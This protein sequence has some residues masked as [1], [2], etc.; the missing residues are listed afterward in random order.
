MVTPD[1]DKYGNYKLCLHYVFCIKVSLYVCFYIYI[2]TSFFSYNNV[3]TLFCY[4]LLNS[5][6]KIRFF[7]ILRVVLRDEEIVDVSFKHRDAFFYMIGSNIKSY[8]WAIHTNILIRLMYSVIHANIIGI[9]ALKS[10]TQ[11]DEV[12]L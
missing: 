6:C 4:V 11:H 1:C 5:V 3:Y 2:Y 7:F 8:I 12:C 10:T 9:V